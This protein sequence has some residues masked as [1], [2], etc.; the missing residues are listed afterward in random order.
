MENNDNIT[1]KVYLE[2]IKDDAIKLL[3]RLL[4]LALNIIMLVVTIIR[5]DKRI[6]W[7]VVAVVVLLLSFLVIRGCM[8]DDTRTDSEDDTDVEEIYIK[9]SDRVERPQKAHRISNINCRRNFNDLNDEQLVAAKKIGIKPIASRDDV[10]SASR[11]LDET[12]DYDA[13]FVDK[14]THSLPYLVPEAAKL[15]S[16][17][18]RNFQDSLVMKHL[19]PAKI[20]V[21]SLLRTKHD[22]KRLSRGNVN[23]SKNSTHCYATTFDITYARF[24]GKHGKSTDG[25]AKMKAVLAEVLRDL[26]KEGRC[27]VKHEVKQPCFHVT[28]RK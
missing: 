5:S 22:V 25:A 10:E 7:G 27:Y 14:L 1:P 6:G 15:L 12:D 9:P 13:Y 21:T 3:K 11:R 18:G 2:R 26:K 16:D 23:A 28:T 20:I 17:I 24:Y 4:S 19:P 8:A